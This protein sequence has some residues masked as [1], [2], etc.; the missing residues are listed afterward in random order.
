MFQREENSNT[1][2]KLTML[3]VICIIFAR[4]HEKR[5]ELFY[6]LQWTSRKTEPFN[7]ME[8][9]QDVFIY[10]GCNYTNC[11]ITDN[12]AYFND[13]RYFDVILFNAPNIRTYLP[14]TLPPKRS[15]Y[16]KYVFVSTESSANYPGARE[17]N[18]IFNWTWTYKLDSDICFSYITVKDQRGVVIG[19]KEHMHWMNISEMKPTSKY[20][21]RKLRKK[22]KAAAWFVSNC[23]TMSDR[24]RFAQSL[25]HELEKYSQ[26]LDI[27]GECGK[28]KCPT[29]GYYDGCY[30]LIESDYYFYLAFENSFSED[31]V[32]EKLLTA[33]E[34]FAVPIVYG[35]A[36]YTR[37]LCNVLCT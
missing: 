8:S 4:G 31:Y 10:K 3:I 27:Y 26:V 19:P 33:L 21:K 32:T 37:Y 2:V 18:G 22:R 28:L 12:K 24:L 14:I 6:I 29:D 30:A 16:Q 13:V 15:E 11:F 5:K 17:Y 35:G 36:N 7:F 34:H 23:D 25:Q 20:I 9:G 1:S